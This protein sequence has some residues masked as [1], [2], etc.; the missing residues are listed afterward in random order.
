MTSDWYRDDILVGGTWR[1]VRRTHQVVNPATGW[2]VGCAAKAD[3]A[4]VDAAVRAAG[5]ALVEWRAT[6]PRVR[7]EGLTA[8]HT[9][10]K[11]RR[12]ELTNCIV[13]ELGAPIRLAREAHVD[14]ALDVL[15][16]FVPIAEELAEPERAGSSLVLARPAGVAACITPWNYPLYQLIAKVGAALAAGC[17]VVAKPAELTPMSAYLLADAVLA[18]GLPAGMLNLVPGSGTEVGAALV[19]HRGIATVS[20]TGSTAVGR[21]VGRTAG[22]ALQRMSLELGGKSASVVLDD[23]DLPS[24][25]RATVESACYNSGQTCSAWTRLLVPRQYYEEALQLAADRA[26]TLAVGDPT[27]E[28]TDLGPLVSADQRTTVSEH[29]ARA[30]ADGVRLVAGGSERPPG[31]DA[32]HY[33]LP[34]ILA[35]VSTADEISREEV[36]GPVLVVQ[37]HDGDDDAVRMANDSDYGLAGAVWSTDQSRALQVAARMQTGQ[38]DL[39]GAAFN[40]V[41]PFGG[42]KSSGV[43]RELGRH[44]VHE[45]CEFTSVQI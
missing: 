14:Q 12:D 6:P 32:G 41:A 43:G 16:G 45:F 40:P 5:D 24:A 38:V 35:D 23:A 10:L 37:A 44:G 4:D 15:A 31:L 21:Q 17:S 2:P 29:V 18:A 8:L 27:D 30:I 19:G 42:W 9:E 3:R 39:N 1:P 33:F 22:E 34:T 26:N 20:F 25:V 11:G 28:A 13:A 36:F 7:A